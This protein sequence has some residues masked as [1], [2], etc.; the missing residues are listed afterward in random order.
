MNPQKRFKLSSQAILL[1][2]ISAAYP[3]TGYCVAAGRVEFAIGDVESVMA[4][5]SR[6]PLGRGADIN[7]GESIST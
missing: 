4:N 2:A 6:H 3:V 7:A 1:A 5:G